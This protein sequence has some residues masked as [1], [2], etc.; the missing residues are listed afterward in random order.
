MDATFGFEQWQGLRI[1]CLLPIGERSEVSPRVCS[2]HEE[3]EE[4]SLRRC[5]NT[6]S[7]CE[8]IDPETGFLAQVFTFAHRHAAPGGRMTTALSDIGSKVAV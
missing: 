2:Q 7:S 6:G 1:R 8:R 4:E 3:P 5:R